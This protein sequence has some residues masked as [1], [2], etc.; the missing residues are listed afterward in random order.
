MCPLA[1]MPAIFGDRYRR[2][3]IHAG[4]R[5]EQPTICRLFPVQKF[6]GNSCHRIIATDPDSAATEKFSFAWSSKIVSVE[7]YVN[8]TV[9]TA[10]RVSIAVAAV[11]VAI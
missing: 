8:K 6:D 11:A 1:G 3:F 7:Q 5:S 4:S 9:S 2:D 10:W